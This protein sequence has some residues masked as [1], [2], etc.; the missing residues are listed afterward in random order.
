MIDFVFQV[1]K[2][3]VEFSQIFSGGFPSSQLDTHWLVHVIQMTE[4]QNNGFPRGT[5]T[6]IAWNVLLAPKTKMLR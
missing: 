2:H 5:D 1:S 4:L 6:G 3:F